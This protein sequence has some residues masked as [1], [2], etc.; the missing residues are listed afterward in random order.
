[1]IFNVAFGIG[2]A[3]NVDF[4]LYDKFVFRRPV[5]EKQPL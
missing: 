5:N 2:L 4:I 1:V 3:A